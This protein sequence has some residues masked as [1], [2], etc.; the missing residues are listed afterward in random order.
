MK[1][2]KFILDWSEVWAL[3]IPMVILMT[4][5]RQPFYLRSVVIY[6]IV[7]FFLD[8]SI[9]VIGYFHRRLHFP[10]WLQS[11]NYLYNVHSIL[12]F[13]CF[14]VFFDRT[15]ARFK[16]LRQW[17][18]WA[19]LIILLVN[20]SFFEGFVQERTFSSRL[21]TLEAGI[22]MFYCLQYY[23][24]RLREEPDLVKRN[25]EFWVVTGLSI[26][27]VINFF[28]FLFYTTIV[29][30]YKRF[31]QDIWDVHNIA[32]IVFCLFLAKAFYDASRR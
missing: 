1:I 26:Y 29:D 31:T 7:A 18:S 6:V 16:K 5:P 2:L 10:A 30:T 12:R 24:S 9:D 27:V 11:N 3:L 23:L 15:D 19:A 20:F 25:P 17:I 8:L 28:I 14:T 22:L 13:S 32:Y 4:R 21:L